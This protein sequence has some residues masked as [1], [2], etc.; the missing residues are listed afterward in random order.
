M[1]AERRSIVLSWGA[2]DCE[3][4]LGRLP[5]ERVWAMLRPLSWSAGEACVA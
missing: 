2:N 3:S 5:L 4:K 1:R